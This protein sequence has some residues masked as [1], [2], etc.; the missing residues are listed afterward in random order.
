M[1]D[2]V[3]SDEAT[4]LWSEQTRSSLNQKSTQDFH[5]PSLRG[6]PTANVVASDEATSL[7]S[8]QTK[9]SPQSKIDSRLRTST[10]RHCECPA[11]VPPKKTGMT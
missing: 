8:E 2:V 10:C 3:A 6:A 5:L 7:W 9:S 4:S 11:G 1:G